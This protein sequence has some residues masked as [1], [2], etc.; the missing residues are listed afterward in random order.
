MEDD[1]EEEE[2]TEAERRERLRRTEQEADLKHAQDLLGDDFGNIGISNNRKAKV[3]GTV[4]AIDGKDPNNTV[5][6]ATL[7]LFNPS[8]KAQFE[9]LRNTLV[10][11]LTASSK[12]A[13]Y[14]LFL[15]ELA[16][17][18]AADLPSDQV[19]KV[20][21]ALTTLS[22]EKMKAEKASEKGGKKTKAAKTKTTL[23]ASRANTVDTNTYEDDA[24]G[25][26]VTPETAFSNSSAQLLTLNSDDFM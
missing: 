26:Y 9:Q 21:S 3:S 18:L 17:Q 12:K 15:Q 23:V 10:P 24:F 2:E 4:I 14:V 1:D 22:N 13:H 19:K 11:I 5:D 16:K 25:E 7:P 6:I 20:S 8:T